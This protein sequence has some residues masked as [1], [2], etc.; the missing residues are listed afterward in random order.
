MY[1]LQTGFNLSAVRVACCVCK[2][3]PVESERLME[4]THLFGRLVNIAPT[5]IFFAV[6]MTSTEFSSGGMGTC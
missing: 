3:A 1:P 4:G 2:E 5:G 6:C